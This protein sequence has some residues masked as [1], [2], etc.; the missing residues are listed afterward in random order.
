LNAFVSCSND[1]NN[2]VVIGDIERNTNRQLRVQRGVT[3]FDLC[4]RPSF[5]ITGGQDKLIR[6]WNPYVLNKPAGVL[7]GHKTA[8]TELAMNHLNSHIISVSEDKIIKIWSAR[9]LQCLQT[10]QDRITHRPENIISAITYDHTFRRLITA[11]DSLRSYETYRQQKSKTVRTHTAPIVSSLYNPNF[12]QVVTGAEDASI[13]V[14]NI[15]TGEKI[16]QFRSIPDSDPVAS[17]EPGDDLTSMAFD[18]SCRRLITSNRMGSM[19]VWNF[20]NGHMLQH[21]F[22][23]TKTEI[24]Q[25]LYVQQPSDGSKY[26]CSVGWDKNVTLFRDDPGN[27][28]TSPARVLT[29]FFMG[30]MK[31][32]HDDVLCV[33]YCEPNIL[34][35]GSVDGKIVIWNFESGHVKATLRDPCVHMQSPEQ[36]A[37][38]RLQFFRRP[39]VHST[40]NLDKNAV[41][42]V[43]PLVSAH[44]DGF[45]R[46]WD[47]DS[48]SMLLEVL[49]S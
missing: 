28:N 17:G 43:M 24:T 49:E 25:C 31:G 44:A 47:I 36:R 9:T 12:H 15:A 42:G 18:Q 22:T 46:F 14:W 21:M 37:V 26:V 39:P 1:P 3:C 23:G 20:N 5:L 8:V 7:I 38:E 30:H 10:L 6:L 32:H 48:A 13:C 19:S 27:M 41:S 4:H 40:K 29:G 33:D 34:A 2:T 35:T 45:I 16:F 11:H